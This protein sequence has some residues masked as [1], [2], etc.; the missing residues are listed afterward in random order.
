MIQQESYNKA[1][2]KLVESHYGTMREFCRDM[3]ISYN[4]GRK[5]MENPRTMRIDF[6]QKL[7]SKVGCDVLPVIN[8][9]VE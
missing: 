6:A 1:V 9:G 8:E 5:Y 7:S 3:K 2:W 4:T